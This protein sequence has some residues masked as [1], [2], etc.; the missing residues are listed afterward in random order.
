VFEGENGTA[1]DN[2][3]LGDLKLPGG[4]GAKRQISVCFDIDADGVLTVYATDKTTKRRHQ[5]KFMDQ[6]QLSKEEIKRM[7]EE[8]AEY[9]AEDAEN[10]ERVKAKNLLEEYLYRK[11]RAIEVERRKAEDALSAVELMIQQVHND[12]VSS[13]R[14]FLDDLEGLKQE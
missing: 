2:S 13:A 3:L 5:K 6:G 12:Q 9:M 10:R 4:D 1:R 7:T 14:K 8:A 11:R